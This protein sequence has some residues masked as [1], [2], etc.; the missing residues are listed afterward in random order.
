[1][2]MGWDQDYTVMHQGQMYE[3][4]DALDKALKAQDKD[5]A[6]KSAHESMR[7]YAKAKGMDWDKKK[8]RHDPEKG[9][10]AW[11]K[12]YGKGEWTDH[13][14]SEDPSTKMIAQSR[15][16]NPGGGSFGSITDWE[17]VNDYYNTKLHEYHNEGFM[18]VG[19]EAPKVEIKSEPEPPKDTT[20]STHLASARAFVGQQDTDNSSGASTAAKFGAPPIQLGQ[21]S[22][23]AQ[24]YKN[25]IKA[26]L[27]PTS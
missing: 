8:G 15:K 4:Q 25:G 27:F 18:K 3:D 5:F 12:T 1:M 19:D 17:G 6:K 20:P 21:A 14:W 16:D 23:F 2:S 10:V 22:T 9:S 26:K 7:Q 24:N 11:E 13:G